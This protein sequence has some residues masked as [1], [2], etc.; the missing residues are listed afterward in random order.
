MSSYEWSS[1]VEDWYVVKS[2]LRFV[3]TEGAVSHWFLHSSD[4][5]LEGD[6]NG[7]PLNGP[8]A[9]FYIF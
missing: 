6:D 7:Q 3:V 2:A 1:P 4:S 9:G 8:G 5:V